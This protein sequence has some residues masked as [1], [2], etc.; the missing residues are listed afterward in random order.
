M[1]R[2]RKR[3]LLHCQDEARRSVISFY[4]SNRGY[5]VQAGFS[6]EP[7]IPDLALIV[8]DPITGFKAAQMCD[9]VRAIPILVLA[10]R[11]TRMDDFPVSASFLKWNS[12][13]VE[14]LDRVATCCARKRGPRGKQL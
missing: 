10:C 9:Q 6:S 4:L 12:A 11:Q 13:P 5:V 7:P 8:D 14:I 1:S 3:V 2:P